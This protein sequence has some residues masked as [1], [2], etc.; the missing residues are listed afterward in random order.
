MVGA[1]VQRGLM[2][3]GC[4][5]GPSYTP[6]K[7]EEPVAVESAGLSF[8]SFWDWHKVRLRPNDA[9]SASCH[10]STR[11]IK[12]T[13][14][15]QRVCFSDETLMEALMSNILNDIMLTASLFYLMIQPHTQHCTG[16][17]LRQLSAAF[18][19]LKK[20]AGVP[21]M[22]ATSP[23]KRVDTPAARSDDTRGMPSRLLGWLAQPSP[24][25]WPAARDPDRQ[26]DQAALD[27]VYCGLHANSCS[28]LAE[29]LPSSS[30]AV[31]RAQRY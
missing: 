11:P 12:G 2:G 27:D 10:L 8:S 9:A 6:A 5:D 16:R 13:T 1:E 19:R 30:G 23:L 22:Q 17:N 3:G 31:P 29:V 24:L 15:R 28:R 7:P 25:P 20:P 4:G 14:P 26:G 21:L 18:L